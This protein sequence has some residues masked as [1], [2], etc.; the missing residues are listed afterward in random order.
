MAVT[1]GVT[2]VGTLPQAGASSSGSRGHPTSTDTVE[3]SIQG[4]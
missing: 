3:G 4:A 1:E 2:A